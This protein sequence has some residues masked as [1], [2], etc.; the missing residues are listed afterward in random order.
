[1]TQAATTHALQARRVGVRELLC[2]PGVPPMFEVRERD[3]NRFEI[4]E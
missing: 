1:M 2:W 3:G 4:V